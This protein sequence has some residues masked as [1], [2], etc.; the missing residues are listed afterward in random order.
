[1]ER[2]KILANRGRKTILRPENKEGPAL[3]K[4]SEGLKKKSGKN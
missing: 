3:D 4:K 2:S 1:L